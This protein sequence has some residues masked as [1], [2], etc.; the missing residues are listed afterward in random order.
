MLSLDRA[1]AHDRGAP[2]IST[3]STRAGVSWDTISWWIIEKTAGELAEWSSRLL[4]AIYLVIFVDAIIVEVP[5]T[6]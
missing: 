6:G 4:D 2:R 3:R 5:V 1:W